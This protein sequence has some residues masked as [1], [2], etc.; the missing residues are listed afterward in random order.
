M[1]YT[2]NSFLNKLRP[3]VM[4]DMTTTKILASLTAAQA[5]IESNKGNSGLTQKANNLFGIKG[6][7]NGQA[8]QM[9]TTEYYNGVK[10]R[11]LANFR[12][13][14]SW[15]E[16]VDD[17]SSLFNRLARYKNLRGETDYVKACNNVQADGYAT[18]PTYAT[19]LLNIINTYK[20]YEWDRECTN[21]IVEYKPALTPGEYYPLLKKGSRGKYV[22]AWQTYLNATGYPCGLVDGKFGNN[23]RTA[24]FNFQKDHPACGTPDGIIGKNTWNAVYALTNDLISA[25]VLTA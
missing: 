24:V 6:T 17:H 10:Q 14:P 7:Y 15:Q 18:S 4:E 25:M 13:Y 11:V 23:T 20:L 9:Y 21:K 12:A 8:V 1:A 2:A 5:F 3:Y 16:S 22:V 19:T